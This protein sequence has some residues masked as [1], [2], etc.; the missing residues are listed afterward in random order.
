MKNS[1]RC[2]PIVTSDPNNRRLRVSIWQTLPLFYM[3]EKQF[4][5]RLFTPVTSRT[6][7]PSILPS[8]NPYVTSQKSYRK[9]QALLFNSRENITPRTSSTSPA[10]ASLRLT[11][12]DPQVGIGEGATR[13]PREEG[14]GLRGVFAGGARS[15][16]REDGALHPVPRGPPTLSCRDYGYVV[17]RFSAGGNIAETLR[18][19]T[20]P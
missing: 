3:I 5:Y 4:C 17:L 16:S 11:S 8:P 20:L 14:I 19:C 12:F 7:T 10:D 13:T 1:G 18:I 2:L 15:R 6:I 9:P